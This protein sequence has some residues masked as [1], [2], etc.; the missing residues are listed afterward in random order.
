MPVAVAIRHAMA[1]MPMPEAT[2]VV[3]AVMPAAVMPAAMTHFRHAGLFAEILGVR[4]R[5]SHGRGWR[6]RDAPGD[7]DGSKRRR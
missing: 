7:S 5:R 1:A 3:T 2:P 4:R 6:R